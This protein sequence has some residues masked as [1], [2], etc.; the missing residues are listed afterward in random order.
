MK[1]TN[2]NFTEITKLEQQNNINLLKIKL[3][4]GR[5]IFICDSFEL[6]YLGDKY[7]Y[8]EFSISGDFETQTGEVSRPT[9]TITNPNYFLNPLVLSGS[10]LGSLVVRYQL[11]TDFEGGVNL[12][13]VRSNQWKLYQVV[14][15]S[16]TVVLQL[17]TLVDAAK[18]TIPPRQYFPPIFNHVNV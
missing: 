6:E 9:L 1:D 11:E 17:R 7:Q 3:P 16:T 15:V 13:L 5:Y 12:K 18:R 8:L 10:L 4:D 2:L 14:G